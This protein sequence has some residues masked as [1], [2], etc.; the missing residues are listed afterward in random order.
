MTEFEKPVKKAAV[1]VPI[2][3]RDDG[4]LQL[5]LI[6]RSSGGIHG[7]QLAFPG[8]KVEPQDRSMRETALRET[9]EEIGI[10][11][12]KIQILAAL[13]LVDTKTTGFRISPFLARIIPPNTWNRQ[14]REV[15]EIVEVRVGDLARPE[16]HGHEEKHF[17]T[18]SAP[19]QTP[20]YRVGLYQIWG[21]T[22]RILQPLI[23]RLLAGEWQV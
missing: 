9:Q 7:N 13:P 5:I 14:A 18:W 6:R 15:A 17:P 23:P 2:Y 4:D 12:D 1:L 21:A 19:R 3:R 11:S 20:V 8:G 10:T 16:A 22:Y